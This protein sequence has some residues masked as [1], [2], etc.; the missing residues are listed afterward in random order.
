MVSGEFN[1]KET[2][3]LM[4]QHLLGGDNF[5]AGY[6]SFRNKD[7]NAAQFKS[8]EEGELYR[9]T[10]VER[11]Q[12]GGELSELHFRLE[13]GSEGNNED[14]KIKVV[15]HREG[16][17][18]SRQNGPPELVDRFVGNLAIVNEYREKL[19]P[20]NELMEDYIHKKSLSLGGSRE[21]IKMQ[22]VRAFR[23]LVDEHFTSIDYTSEERSV[24]VAITANVGLSLATLDLTD[25]RYPSISGFDGN[26]IDYNGKI[27]EF[28]KDYLVLSEGVAK[29][30]FDLVA[31]HLHNILTNSQDFDSLIEVL[32]YI[33]ETYDI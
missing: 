7:I 2:E 10:M 32:E 16:Y 30:D 19:T 9:T 31:G 29:P 22:T 8:D 18:R 28:F 3:L 5:G 26:T 15:A 4:L 25:D 24:Y 27:S 1:L 12:E 17:F 21:Q 13:V 20:L 11:A 6:D 14:R 23:Q 33:E